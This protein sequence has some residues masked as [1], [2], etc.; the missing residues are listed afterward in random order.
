MVLVCIQLMK[1]HILVILKMEI[2]M[3]L[4]FQFLKMVLLEVECGKMEK[5]LVILD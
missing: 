5:K 1:K 2:K 3:V 4:V